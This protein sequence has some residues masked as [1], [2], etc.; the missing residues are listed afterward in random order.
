M[1]LKHPK[2]KLEGDKGV[3]KLV[4]HLWTRS[5][6]KETENK[7]LADIS[8]RNNSDVNN[9]WTGQTKAIK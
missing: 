6:S 2:T 5:G 1:S 7:S 3:F 4:V 8:S 9:K